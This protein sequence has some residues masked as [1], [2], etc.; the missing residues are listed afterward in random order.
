MG[1]FNHPDIGWRDNMAGH[2]QSR[3]FPESTYHK[4]LF[5]V[6]KEPA[7]GVA[8]LNHILLNKEGLRSSKAALASVTMR[9]WT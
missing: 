3:G 6:T 5:Q 1:D 7:R 8:V 9:W 4:F 2:E